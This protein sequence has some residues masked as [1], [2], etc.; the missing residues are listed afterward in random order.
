MQRLVAL[1]T[2]PL[3]REALVAI[4][5][6]I[7]SASIALQKPMSVAFWGPPG[8]Y[9][10]M[11]AL[12]R[13]GSSALYHDCPS[14]PDVFGE[15]ERDRAD[16]GVVPVENSTEGVV[17]YTL[18]MFH[19]TVPAGLRRDLRHHRP[20]PADPRPVPGQDPAP[21]LRAQPIG[22]V[23]PLAGHAPAERRNHRGPADHPA[24][25]RAAADPQGAAIAARRAAE[26]YNIPILFDSIQDNP[27]NRTRFLVIGRNEPPPTGRDKT[28]LLFAVR[29]EPGSLGR[30]LRAFEQHN[31]NLTM[32]A[33]RPAR[34]TAWEYVQFVD[35]QGHEQDEPVR[36]AL[37]DLRQHSHLRQRPGVVPGGG[38]GTPPAWQANSPPRAG[39]DGKEAEP[40]SNGYPLPQGEVASFGQTEGSPEPVGSASGTAAGPRLL[41]GV[42]GLRR[43][44]GSATTSWCWTRRRCRRTRTCRCWRSRSAT[45]TSGVGAD[46]LLVVGRDA[47]GAAF[48]MRMFNPDGTEDMCGNGLRCVGLWAHRA[49]WVTR[50]APFNVAT[51][52]GP[53]A[54]RLLEVADDG[55]S[56]SLRVGMGV[57]QFAP[58]DIPFCVHQGRG[59]RVVGYP[60]D[61][62]GETFFITA[63]NTGST[64]TVIFGVVPP[65]EETFQRVSPLIELHPQFPDAL[66]SSGPRPRRGTIAVRIWERGVGETLGCGTGAWPWASPPSCTIRSAWAKSTRLWISFQGRRAHH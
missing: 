57:P 28:S 60:L 7:I 35:F 52:E 20:Q 25:E 9:T 2:G 54:M 51:K 5:R 21:L 55:R 42:C 44:R 46:G 14:I 24:A 39:E 37:D 10:E 30:A 64:H 12:Q 18:D 47:P 36:Q 11:A 63:M 62:A 43:C 34:G 4:Y 23:P 45:G 48:S 53:K 49:G 16:Y 22:A 31:V 50:D 58:A 29:N 19:E 32:I 33:T 26:V 59:S 1:H 27:N 38:I 56:A 15:V 40:S 41:H 65:D 8:T 6:E 3:P 13:F 17:T 61:V 66:R